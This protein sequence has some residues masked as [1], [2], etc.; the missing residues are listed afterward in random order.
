M[1]LVLNQRA[2]LIEAAKTLSA[3]ARYDNLGTFEFLLDASAP[4]D[5]DAISFIESNPRLQVEHTVTEEI[6]RRSVAA[7][8]ELA[9]GKS[10]SEIGL[11][12]ENIP[13]P[14]GSPSSCGQ[15]GED[16]PD[17]SVRPDGRNA[18]D[19]VPHVRSRRTRR[20]LG[21]SGYRTNSSFDSFWRRSSFTRR[22]RI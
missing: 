14:R 11:K 13:K 17:G 8:L 5:F 3:A 4:D 6:R 7:Q 1:Q 21:I 19:F 15:H 16:R 20:Y 9:R 10:L 2:R 22:C 12:Q 18:R